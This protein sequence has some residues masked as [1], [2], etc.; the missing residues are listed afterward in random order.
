VDRAQFLYDDGT[1][2]RG[3]EVAISAG[4]SWEEWRIVLIARRASGEPSQADLDLIV[5]AVNA[6]DPLN[7]QNSADLAPQV[8]ALVL[9]GN[10]AVELLEFFHP[11]TGDGC[12]VEEDTAALRAAL[13]PFPEVE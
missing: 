13:E 7:V 3:T 11:D 2:Q 10:R 6:Y 4:S 12:S 5:A 1:L 9:A 8:R